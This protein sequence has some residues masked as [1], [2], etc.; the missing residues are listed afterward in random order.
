MHEHEIDSSKEHNYRAP[1]IRFI[2][3][4][5]FFSIFG[6]VTYEAAR[7]MAGPHLAILGAGGGRRMSKADAR[8][9]RKRGL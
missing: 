2:L 9:G 1:A 5:G 6:D 7:S 3:L 8:T 4:L